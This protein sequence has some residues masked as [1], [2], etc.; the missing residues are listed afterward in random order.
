MCLQ[1]FIYLKTFYNFCI[2]RKFLKIYANFKDQLLKFIDT[3]LYYIKTG[4]NLT[5]ILSFKTKERQVLQVILR[6]IFIKVE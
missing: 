3:Q 2:I 1:N 4:K 5:V 6:M